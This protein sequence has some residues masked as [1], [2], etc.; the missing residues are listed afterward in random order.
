M[1]LAIASQQGLPIP[2]RRASEGNHLD[3][4][5]SAE[6]LLARRAGSVRPAMRKSLL[7][8][9]LRVVRGGNRLNDYSPK[10]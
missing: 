7:L 6:P 4:K 5:K 9:L 2:A 8:L 10:V 3:D 1:S